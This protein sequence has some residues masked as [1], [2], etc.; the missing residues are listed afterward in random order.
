MPLLCLTSCP[1][2][3][4]A[5][6]IARTLVEE[7]LAACV[8]QLPGITSTYRWEDAVHADTEVL[9][10]IKSTRA[11]LDALRAR[12]VE[13]HPYAVPEFIAVEITDGHAPYLAWVAQAVAPR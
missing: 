4:S 3:A 11:R 1:D 9:L 13:L 10:L 12:V 7:R 5:S 8:N 6:R 2:R